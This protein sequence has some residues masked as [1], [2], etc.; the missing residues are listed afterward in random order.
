MNMKR[1]VQMT[2]HGA[3]LAWSRP[4]GWHSVLYN[5]AMAKARVPGPLFMPAHVSIE[6][7]NLCNARCPVCETGNLSMERTQGMLDFDNYRRFIDEI[8]PHTT[9][10]M[11]YFMG[12]PF[13]NR[14]AYEMI[15]YAREKG[16]Y[17]ETC[18]NGDFVDAKGLIYSD[19]NRISFQIGGMTQE[20]HAIYR[21]RSNLVKVRRNL[22]ALLE[23]RR[24]HPES[25][26]TIEIGFIVM[27]HNEHEVRSFLDW[28]EEIGADVASVIDPCV[29]NVVEAHALL[30]EDRRYWFYDEDALKR[31]ILRPKKILDNECTW[32][33]NSVMIT[34][35]GSV[36]PCCRDTQG[37]HVFGNA[38]ETP[39]RE[40]WNGAAMRDFRRKIASDQRNIDICELCSG[41][42]VP[43]LIK[44][45]N[46]GFEVRRLS[47]EATPIEELLAEEGDS[48]EG[49]VGAQ[50][51]GSERASASGY[52]TARPLH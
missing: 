28:A 47:N 6:P 14:N 4:K 29:R 40:V 48:V 8:A 23:E 37:R 38:F 16:I 39:L 32:V 15:R 11:F 27:R 33:W 22:E 25:S 17:V 12:E 43:R 30:P 20:T 21:V 46:V 13:L 1:A 2:S 7:T 31:G 42:G 18:S 19:I 5:T 34:W 44:T 41:F 9:V 52:E 3:K 36:V 45:D 51:R 49:L 24:R 10:L 35:D 50:R 26:V